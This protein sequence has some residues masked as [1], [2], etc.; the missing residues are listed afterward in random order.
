[1]RPY[2]THEKAI[3]VVI[4][5]FMVVS[6]HAPLFALDDVGSLRC[7]QESIMTGETAFQVKETCGEPDSILVKGLA[8]EEWVYNFGPTKFIYYLTFINGRLERI[9]VGEYGSYHDSRHLD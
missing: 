5:L 8:K 9:K 6:A 3:T 4:S 7:D 2:L 1:M